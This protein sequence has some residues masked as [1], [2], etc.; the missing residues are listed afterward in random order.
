MYDCKFYVRFLMILWCSIIRCFPQLNAG[1][2]HVTA[3]IVFAEIGSVLVIGASETIITDI[4]A[5][6]RP[7]DEVCTVLFIDTRSLVQE[8][9][10]PETLVVIILTGNAPADGRTAVDAFRT[11]DIGA[12]NLLEYVAVVHGL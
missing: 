11:V 6:H 12:G 2:R 5:S 4:P 9:P 8:P 3:D 7:L 10:F 1:S